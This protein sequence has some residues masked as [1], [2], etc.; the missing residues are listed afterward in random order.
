MLVTALCT[1]NNAGD[2]HLFRPPPQSI[3]TSDVRERLNSLWSLGLLFILR[4][5]SLHQRAHNYG[6][7]FANR[8]L[9]IIDHYTR[10]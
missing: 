3:S 8:Q 6:V 7:G 1:S 4:T 5:F 9:F 10:A 2:L